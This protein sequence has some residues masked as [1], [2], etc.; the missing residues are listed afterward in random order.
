[1]FNAKAP[2]SLITACEPEA[3]LTPTTISGG[4]NDAWVTQ[5]TADADARPS[6]VSPVST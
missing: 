5:F 3:A 6:F 4:S 1:M 2:L